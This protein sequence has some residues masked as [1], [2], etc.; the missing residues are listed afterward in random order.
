MD[1]SSRNRSPMTMFRFN[2]F[3]AWPER[4][5][6]YVTCY[7]LTNS[8]IDFSSSPEER[9]AKVRPNHKR[10]SVSRVGSSVALASDEADCGA[11]S[12]C[13]KRKELRLSTSALN[14]ELFARERIGSKVDQPLKQPVTLLLLRQL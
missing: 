9:P 7:S 5:H 11:S 3:G 13:G 4:S 6:V 8:V 2:V 10:I 12:R 14:I 1:P